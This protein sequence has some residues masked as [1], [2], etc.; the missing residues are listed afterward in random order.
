MTQMLRPLTSCHWV[1]IPSDAVPGAPDVGGSGGRESLERE[2]TC[3]LQEAN[4]ILAGYEVIALKRSVFGGWKGRPDSPE[5]VIAGK[6][7]DEGAALHW[8][9]LQV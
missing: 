3:P 5:R 7:A 4:I 1:G 6:A 8:S 2:A 9:K